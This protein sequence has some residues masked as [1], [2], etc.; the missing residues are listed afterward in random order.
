MTEA[1]QINAAQKE[2]DLRKANLMLAKIDALEKLMASKEAQNLLKSLSELQTG[3]VEGSA[4]GAVN[5]IIGSFSMS[6][7]MINMEKQ[8]Y[9]GIVA[10][11]AIPTLEA[12]PTAE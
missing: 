8:K 11:S 7:M 2:L 12:I 3:M 10:Q 1:E 5:N 6:S 9:E 4:L